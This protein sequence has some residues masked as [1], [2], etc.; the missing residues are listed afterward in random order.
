MHDLMTQ[1]L[2]V[3]ILLFCV[4]AMLNAGL[5]LTVR[6]ILEP[7]HNVR[8]AAFS[9]AASYVL[10]PLLA[11]LVAWILSLA[12]PLR[13]GLILVSLTAGAEA[14]PKVAEMAR[15][16]VAFAVG[17]LATQLVMT[18]VYI[19]LI[20]MVFLPEAQ[21]Q[22]GPLMLKLAVVILLPLAVSLFLNARYGGLAERLRPS[23]HKA[24]TLF[25]V[26][27]AALVVM[28]DSAE[29]VRLIGTR[30]IAAGALFVVLSFVGGYLLGGPRPENRRT[31]AIMSC[32][33]NAGI[34]L[35]I[36]SQ[37]FGDSDVLLMI[38]VTVLVML[39]L[40]LPTAY[41]L[42]HRAMPPS[43]GTMLDGQPQAV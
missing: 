20:L 37:V 22:Y 19:P 18:I 35:M 14:G 16:N 12:E 26:L 28:A 13:M 38:T 29:M 32:G 41:W 15:A 21:I 24:S 39:G 10:T 23:L 1:A 34:S 36:A 42:G 5:A 30:A 43:S 6:Q 17:L 9:F 11:V 31:L 4:T 3:V 33:R 8:L 2:H 40:L 27:L 25:L 7:F